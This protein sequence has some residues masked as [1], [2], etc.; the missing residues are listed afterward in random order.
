MLLK[1]IKVKDFRQLKESSMFLSLLIL[2]AM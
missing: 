1:S 2:N